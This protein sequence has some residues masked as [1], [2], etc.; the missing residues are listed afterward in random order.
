ENLIERLMV[1]GTVQGDQAVVLEDIAPELRAVVAEQPAMP[2]L[3]DQQERSE[4]EHLAKVL[5]ECGGNRALAA[6]RLGISRSTLWRK[7]RK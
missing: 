5:E 1:L 7:L 3:R 4:Q 6:Q 2:A